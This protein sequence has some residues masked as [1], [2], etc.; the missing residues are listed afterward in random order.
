MTFRPFL[1]GCSLRPIWSRKA[2]SGSSANCTVFGSP[3]SGRRWRIDSSLWGKIGQFAYRAE[4]PP[5]P[6]KRKE[7]CHIC[8]CVYIYM[9]MLWSYYL[10]KVWPFQGLLS[11]P[12]SFL[13]NFYTGFIP[14]RAHSSYH[15]VF[16]CPVIRQFCIEKQ[17]FSKIVCQNCFYSEFPFLW[18]WK[19]IC[20]G[21]C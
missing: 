20:L 11:G 6:K 21:L 3:R 13:A 19:S 9:W 15:F 14:C 10:G 7:R 17:R 16:S 5:P 8:M 2:E 1:P 4:P 12:R 18:F